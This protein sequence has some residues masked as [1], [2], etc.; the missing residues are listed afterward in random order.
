[1]MGATPDVAPAMELVTPGAPTLQVAPPTIVAAY[2]VAGVVLFGILAVLELLARVVPEAANVGVFLWYATYLYVFGFAAYCLLDMAWHAWQR[3]A[4]VTLLTLAIATFVVAWHW[5]DPRSLSGE[6]TQEIACVL[7]QLTTTA[8]HGYREYCFLGYPTRQFYLPAVP[9]LLFGHSMAALYAGASLYLLLGLVVFTSGVVRYFRYTH[10]GDWMN[11][12]LVGAIFHFY[13][14]NFLTFQYEQSAFP[15]GLALLA[16]GLFFHYR[17]APKPYLLVLLGF[18]GLYLIYTYT[19]GLALLGLELVVLLYW[20]I[21]E[22]RTSRGRLPLMGL[23]LVLL[24]FLVTSFSLRG[25]IRLHDSSGETGKQLLSDLATTFEHLLFQNHGNPMVS[26]LFNFVFIALV[27]GCALGSFGPRAVPVALWIIATIIAAEVAQGYAYYGIDYRLE[28]AT[29]AIPVFLGLLAVVCA[30]LARRA[31]AWHLAVSALIIGSTGL[32]FHNLYM[33]SLFPNPN[34]AFIQWLGRNVPAPRSTAQP[35]SL[36]L[37]YGAD[38]YNNLTSLYDTLQ[39]FMPGVT[40]TVD[41]ALDQRLAATPQKV[42]STMSGIL[43]LASGPTATP[44]AQA[45]TH[46]PQRYRYDGQ[47]HTEQGTYLVVFNTR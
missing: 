13:N 33:K 15:A 45:L 3:K 39:Y 46:D 41:P 31:N 4:P 36:Y 14:F 42:L 40:T 30:P 20:A 16:V 7:S 1:M 24:M 32:Y 10:T 6:A 17:V 11:A 18:A 8:D 9:T 44:A 26:P 35:T 38:H 2:T 22:E 28:R 37:L 25:D 43:V 47:F 5:Q 27:L 19:P 12:I 29:V 21:W 23:I 34:W